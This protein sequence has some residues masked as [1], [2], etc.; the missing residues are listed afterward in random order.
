MHIPSCG[1]AGQSILS[2]AP[3]LEQARQPNP[4]YDVA[5]WLF[6]PNYYCDYRYILGT[7][8]ERPLICVGINPS[9]AAPNALDNTLKSVERIALGNGYD[10]FLMFNV[11]AQRAT[12]PDD[13]E[14]ACNPQ[15]HRENMAAFRWALGQTR[16]GSPAVWAAWGAII[17]KR[18][19]LTDCLRD[20]IAIGEELGAC[21]YSAGPFSKRGHP[22][23]PLYLRKESG[24]ERFDVAAYLRS[25]L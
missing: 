16:G 14:Q 2:F 20:M 4:D 7:T 13:M 18:P 24:L 8:G 5:R 22:H 11:Y 21:W 15:L 3:A 25:C 1:T 12:R 23:H 6:V 10:S 9:T 17:E 19:Y